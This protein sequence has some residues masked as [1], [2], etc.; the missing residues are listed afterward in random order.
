M[1]QGIN[2]PTEGDF[3]LLRLRKSLV[4]SLCYYLPSPQP[5]GYPRDVTTL[6][7]PCLVG[8]Q[9]L[10]RWR[11]GGPLILSMPPLLTVHQ[12]IRLLCWL[13]LCSKTV[14]LGRCPTPPPPTTLTWWQ[15]ERGNTTTSSQLRTAEVLVARE[16]VHT[17]SRTSRREIS[18][19]LSR[20]L[21]RSPRILSRLNS[22]FYPVSARF[23][24]I[25]EDL[26]HAEISYRTAIEICQM[27]LNT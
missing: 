18:R 9:R 8:W 22:S 4:V 3:Y 19:S 15:T 25:K 13:W 24:F 14:L 11:V 20:Q 2:H 12:V 1:D 27:Y 23:P 6:P 16:A 21:L 7:L 10:Q 5:R 17:T 26:L